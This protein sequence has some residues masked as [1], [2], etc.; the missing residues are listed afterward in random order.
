[1]CIFVTVEEAVFI[2]MVPC[3]GIVHDF[4]ATLRAVKRSFV[5]ERMNVPNA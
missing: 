3:L 1:M 2:Y 4:L 5:R